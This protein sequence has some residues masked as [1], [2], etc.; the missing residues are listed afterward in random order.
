MSHL[1]SREDIRRRGSAWG[2]PEVEAPPAL[3]AAGAAQGPS[4]PAPS[5]APFPAFR[6]NHEMPIPDS[7]VP[8]GT[9]RRGSNDSTATEGTAQGINLPPPPPTVYRSRAAPPQLWLGCETPPD[10][11]DSSGILNTPHFRAF[12]G[13]RRPSDSTATFRRPSDSTVRTGESRRP[14]ILM[15]DYQMNPDLSSESPGRSLRVAVPPPIY[16]SPHMS[17]SERASFCSDSQSPLHSNH[18]RASAGA[19]PPRGASTSSVSTMGNR[20]LDGSPREAARRSMP[21]PGNIGGP[22]GPLALCARTNMA[23]PRLGSGPWS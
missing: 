4:P 23:T 1:P 13:F 15:P 3:G 14:S 22:R 11:M 10:P 8:V 12:Q 7:P 6:R 19:L 21:S 5:A 20:Y 18:V 17:R 9:Q 16:L 2:T